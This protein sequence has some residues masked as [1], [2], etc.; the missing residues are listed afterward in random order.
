[1]YVYIYIYIYNHSLSLS[2]STVMEVETPRGACRDP[3]AE[4]TSGFR[5]N[6]MT[7]GKTTPG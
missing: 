4:G 7:S 3:P 5:P 6:G 1:M 2:R